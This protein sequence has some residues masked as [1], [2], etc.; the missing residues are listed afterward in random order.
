MKCRATTTCN[1]EIRKHASEAGDG[2]A[3][4]FPG[5]GH[6]LSGAPIAGAGEG[7]MARW[8]VA[9]VLITLWIWYSNRSEHAE[10]LGA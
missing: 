6:S 10:V 2:S 1:T 5:A 3:A 9:L 4:S 8:M 7:G